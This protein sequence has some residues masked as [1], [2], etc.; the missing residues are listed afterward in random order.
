MARDAS[1]SFLLKY[2][3][4]DHSTHILT[5]K[6]TA[7]W[8]EAREKPG[9]CNLAFS[10][11]SSCKTPTSFPTL[12]NNAQQTCKQDPFKREQQELLTGA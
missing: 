6:Y 10:L 2:H 11:L 8:V 4:T 7:E 9:L 5:L 1:V 12:G 3:L